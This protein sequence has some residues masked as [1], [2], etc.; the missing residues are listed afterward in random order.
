MSTKIL[1]IGWRDIITN[2]YIIEITRQQLISTRI[3]RKYWAYMGHALQMPTHRVAREAVKLKPTGLGNDSA[4]KALKRT[5][6][7]EVRI[8]DHNTIE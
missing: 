1:D 2:K 4:Q 3:R 8:V 7:R 5:L 6:H